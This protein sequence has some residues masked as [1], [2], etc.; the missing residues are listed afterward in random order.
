VADVWGPIKS[1]ITKLKS[2]RRRPNKSRSN[3]Q[4][5]EKHRLLFL[6]L[7]DFGRISLLILPSISYP[8]YTASTK[9]NLTPKSSKSC[10][11]FAFASLTFV[12]GCFGRH[13]L[14]VVGAKIFPRSPLFN[15]TTS[16][17]TKYYPSPQFRPV[18][19]SFFFSL[20][21]YQGGGRVIAQN[22]TS[23]A[24]C[25]KKNQPDLLAFIPKIILYDQNQD[26]M[27][28]STILPDAPIPYPRPFP[29]RD[30]Q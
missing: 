18:K 17:T 1:F 23:T 12:F 11:P 9:L 28:C 3:L 29:L 19:L 21:I 5:L 16:S 8:N 4:H 10:C 30:R 24:T 22:S 13:L 15:L 2:Y 20:S 26:F 7:L 14:F 6:L 25:S 27:P